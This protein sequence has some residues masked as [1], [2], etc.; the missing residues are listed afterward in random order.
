MNLDNRFEAF[1]LL[2]ELETLENQLRKVKRYRSWE[3]LSSIITIGNINPEYLSRKGM[4]NLLDLTFEELDQKIKE[5]NLK[6]ETL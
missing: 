4:E 3:G 5:I 1:K 6:L 2:S